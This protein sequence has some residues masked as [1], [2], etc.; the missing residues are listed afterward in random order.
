MNNVV[1]LK[2]EPT[3]ERKAKRSG[4]STD[5]RII[6]DGG[7]CPGNCCGHAFKSGGLGRGG[8]HEILES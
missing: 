4:A 3:V 7:V 8:I 5:A 1:K 2:A 6:R